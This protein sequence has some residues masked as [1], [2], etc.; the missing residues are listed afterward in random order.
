MM[1]K[2]YETNDL[3]IGAWLLIRGSVLRGHRKETKRKCVFEFALTQAEAEALVMEYM[4]SECARF[5]EAGRR[6]KKLVHA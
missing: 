6:L 4:E 3:S 1:A 2:N 5:D